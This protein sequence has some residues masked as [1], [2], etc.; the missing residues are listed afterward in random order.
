VFNSQTKYGNGAIAR[1]YLNGRLVHALDLSPKP[2]PDWQ[3]GDDPYSRNLWDTAM[4]AW[5]VPVGQFAGQPLAV[6]IATDAKGEN[7]ADMVWWARPKFVSDPQQQSTFVR[8]AED[9]T[10]TPE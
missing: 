2:N 10:T 4:H 5:T 6:T 9:G 3:E 7:N 8:L 1:L